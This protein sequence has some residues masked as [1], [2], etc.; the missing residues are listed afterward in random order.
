M[1]DPPK[2]GK[3]IA[4]HVKDQ[5]RVLLLCVACFCLKIIH[6]SLRLFWFC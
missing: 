3:T 2:P 1:K 5:V 6:F 4:E